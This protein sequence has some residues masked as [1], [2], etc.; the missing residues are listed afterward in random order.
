MR[1]YSHSST[2]YFN[3]QYLAESKGDV[4]YKQDQRVHKQD[5]TFNPRKGLTCR[6]L[7][8][9]KDDPIIL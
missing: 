4:R 7:R 1:K 6:G 3:E 9:N 5:Q 2:F 8:R